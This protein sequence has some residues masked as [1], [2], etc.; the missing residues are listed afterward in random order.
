MEIQ[1]VFRVLCLLE[2]IVSACGRCVGGV[3]SFF[4]Q[5]PYEIRTEWNER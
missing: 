4:L 1:F 5:K 3:G 2:V